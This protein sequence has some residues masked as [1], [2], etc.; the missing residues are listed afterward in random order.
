[1]YHNCS[2]NTRE[3]CAN[4]ANYEKRCFMSEWQRLPLPQRR[5]S[6]FAR[7]RQGSHS[8]NVP[9]DVHFDSCRQN[10]HSLLENLFSV[11]HLGSDLPVASTDLHRNR[12][13]WSPDC[14]RATPSRRP[15]PTGASPAKLVVVNRPAK[16]I[17]VAHPSTS[18]RTCVRR[19]FKVCRQRLRSIGRMTRSS[20]P[21]R[22]YPF[23]CYNWYDE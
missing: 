12:N 10:P 11:H 19:R 6:E 8:Q 7:C 2:A 17:V 13:R 18:L 14:G 23:K 1:M 3:T 9:R 16:P 20:R 5:S 15:R 4:A 22:D 21:T